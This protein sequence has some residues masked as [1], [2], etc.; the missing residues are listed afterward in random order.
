MSI[1]GT[2]KL[3]QLHLAKIVAD[4]TKTAPTLRVLVALVDPTSG[5]TAYNRYT[6]SLLSAETHAALQQLRECLE[7]DA[8]RSLFEGTDGITPLVP[9]K[10]ASS[11]VLLEHLTAEDTVPNV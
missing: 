3:T 7:R 4:F 1:T 2:S 9:S 6:G 5:T 11:Q 8:A 10:T